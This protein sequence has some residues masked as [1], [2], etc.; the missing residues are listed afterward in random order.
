[1]GFVLVIGPAPIIPMFW[2]IMICIWLIIWFISAGIVLVIDIV[3]VIG[4]VPLICCQLGVSAAWAETAVTAV[5]TKANLATVIGVRI[6][7]L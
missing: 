2:P 4:I 3:P 7:H 6:A 1:M 5:R